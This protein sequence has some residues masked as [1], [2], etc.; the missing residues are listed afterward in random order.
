MQNANLFGELSPSTIGGGGGT[1]TLQEKTVNPTKNIQEVTA[2]EG[3][4]ALSKVTITNIKLQQKAVTPSNVSQFIMADA[5]YDG[6]L[7]ISVGAA[8]GG[9]VSDFFDNVTALQSYSNS[10]DNPYKTDNIYECVFPRL[11]SVDC[12]NNVPALFGMKYLKAVHFKGF[13]ELANYQGITPF[14]STTHAFTVYVPNSML[15]SY[16]ADENWTDLLTYN[17][18]ISLVGE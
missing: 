16:Q 7:S 14:P 11:A 12:Q 3:Y 2:D 10:Y 17:P 4:D 6:L 18:N 15:S 5:G 8:A 13:V 9:K 1:I